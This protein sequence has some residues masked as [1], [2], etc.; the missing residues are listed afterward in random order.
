MSN[1]PEKP[2]DVM[3]TQ[4]QWDAIYDSG[5][6]ILVSASAGSGKTRILVER[7]IEKLKTGVKIDEL[8]IVTFTEA[9]A[10]EMKERIQKELRKTINLPEISVTERQ[11]LTEQLVKL[12][13]ANISTLHAFCLTVIRR[14]YYLID[15]DPVF[16]ML[17]DQT[18]TLLLKE[19]VWEALR[20]KFYDDTEGVPA[21]FYELTANF[22]NDR[23][24]DGLTD[25]V[26]RLYEFARAN[27]NPEAWLSKI[28]DNYPEEDGL[29]KSK[30]FSE[31]MLPLMM[32]MVAAEAELFEQLKL[33][34]EATEG[35]ANIIPVMLGSQAIC[36]AI[37][38]ALKAQD[39]EAA[40]ALFDHPDLAL[41]F[42]SIRDPELKTTVTEI[43]EA[44]NAAKKRLAAIRED[45]LPYLP[46]EIN[47]L[48]GL[49]RPLIQELIGVGQAF[50]ESY[51]LAKRQKGVLDFNDLEHLTLQILQTENTKGIKEAQEYYRHKFSEVLVDEYQDTNGLQEA[52]IRRLTNPK[53]QPGNLFMVGDVKQSIYSF[54]LADPTLFIGKFEQF[55]EADNSDGRLIVLPDNF[56][57]RKEVIDFT[58]LIFEQLMD[59]QVGQIAYDEA[60]KLV[61]GFGQFPQKDVFQ[62]ELL[63][64]EKAKEN[65]DEAEVIDQLIGDSSA[66]NELLLE[67]KTDGELLMTGLKIRELIDN[68]FLLYD[69]DAKAERPAEYRDI[70]LLTP[71]KKNNIAI[72][73]TFKR[74]GIPVEVNDAEN[75]FQATEVRTMISLLQII[76][77]PYQDIPLAAILRSPMVGLNERELAEIRMA[78]KNGSFYEAVLSYS[79]TGP[80]LQKVTEFLDQLNRWRNLVRR[81]NIAQLIW[82]VYQETAYPEYVLG[83]PAGDQRYANLLALAD[84]AKDYENSSYR[85]LYQFIRFI[86]KMQEKDKD[87]AEPIAKGSGNAVRVMTIHASKGL[88]FPIV[89][90]MDMS[91]RFNMADTQANYIF[92]E[93]SGI[94]IKY[95]DQ[96]S[97]V[98]KQTLPYNGIRQLKTRKL[99]SEELRKLYVALTRA[100]QKLFLVGSYKNQEELLKTWQM[101]EKSTDDGLVLPTSLRMQTSRSFMDWLGWSLIRHPD[102]KNFTQQEAIL[103]ALAKHPS[104]FSIHW[105]TETDLQ[106]SYQQLEKQAADIELSVSQQPAT[107]EFVDRAEKILNFSYPFKEAT[108]TT[109]YQS[110]SEIK[111]V[112]DDPD[113]T[114]S[115][116]LLWESSQE[117][118]MKRHRYVADDLAV[119]NFL[120]TEAEPT[121]A[122]IGTATHRV[123]QLLPLDQKPTVETVEALIGRLVAANNFEATV[124]KKIKVPAILE[125]FEQD[126][127][128]FLLAHSDKV[129]R[130][131]PFSMLKKADD[132]FE[133]YPTEADQVLIHG[134]IDGYITLE[135]EIYL[136]DF[137]TD[138]LKNPDDAVELQEVVQRHQGQLRL[139]QQAL[140]QAEKLPVSK[141]FLIL[142]ES[143]K[144]IDIEAKG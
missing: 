52:I 130:E 144:V 142:L 45:F 1:I 114:G 139:Y 26:Y 136:Y 27:P 23:S 125:F 38:T 39:F 108:E 120:A 81:R 30:L 61:A 3:F 129:K 102:I 94:G 85:G 28:L 113:N 71:T 60:A 57:S 107:Q 104:H 66:I 41:R 10:R 68:Q 134:I 141:I 97:R 84:R 50:M 89:F 32:E 7:V 138:H 93:K 24:D 76:D 131:Q 36:Q 99:L 16:R 122:V 140:S 11:M 43:R 77:N 33:A 124:A 8:L 137:K 19:D 6:N 88:E 82:Q 62:P 35:L 73:D 115:E 135:N 112:F 123:L 121:A 83:L 128:Q 91:K 106:H 101:A 133:D 31:E 72:M 12:P 18:E 70:V 86:E 98:R 14:F 25:L 55:K 110:V 9:A 56:R 75:Y 44:R 143:G 100:E 53:N 127:G 21:A 95:L 13:A 40:Y 126:F 63:L 49:A 59:K 2:T 109:S 65:S 15:L 5:T 80:L 69:K 64:Y 58:N 42:P 46:A 20:E 37:L 34:A 87:L 79:T 48:I 74:L 116:K 90:L 105:Y 92:D 67:D 119:P 17:T 29:K 103:P 111:R 47:R 118:A 96:I 132:I 54:R 4:P 51:A 22:S 78:N 117:K